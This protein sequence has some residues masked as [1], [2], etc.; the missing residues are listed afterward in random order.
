MPEP[1]PNNGVNAAAA[2]SP[3][4]ATPNQQPADGGA[5]QSVPYSRFKEVNDELKKYKALGLTPEEVGAAVEYVAESVQRQQSTPQAGANGGANGSNGS[6][7]ME[8]A[9]RAYLLKIMPWLKD[10]EESH[11][12]SKAE[13]DERNAWQTKR[14]RA[15][16]AKLAKDAGYNEDQL[17]ALENAISGI[18]YGNED[19]R[20]AWKHG[21]V[22]AVRDAF[23]SHRKGFVE[24][25]AQRFA[26]QV[27]RQKQ[28]NRA[29]LPPRV[30]G[31]SAPPAP[32][33]PRPK[34]LEEARTLAMQHLAE[35]SP[36]MPEDGLTEG[37]S[38]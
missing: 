33:K 35:T 36:D 18:I 22:G 20:L 38:A 7:D 12:R 30:N 23:E 13:A 14:A 8:Q 25:A 4:A 11:T 6:P 21:D 15:E 3:A 5:E 19:F 37:A 34:N 27:T 32:A 17:D 9:W 10:A 28:A 24:P 1:V 16:L 2:A 31:G 29:E 26:S